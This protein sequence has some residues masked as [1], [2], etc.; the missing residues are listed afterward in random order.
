[1]KNNALVSY[2]TDII[3]LFIPRLDLL[4]TLRYLIMKGNTT[5][6]QYRT[7]NVPSVVED[8]NTN[9]GQQDSSAVD[10]DAVSPIVVIQ[11][12]KINANSF[13]PIRLILA[14]T[15]GSTLVMKLDQSRLMADLYTWRA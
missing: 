9:N 5:Y 6:Y 2:L 1:M 7:G 4:P 12:I 13:H 11:I 3:D 10:D 15:M 14:M 8:I